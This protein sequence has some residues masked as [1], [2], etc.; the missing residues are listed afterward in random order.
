MMFCV[1][2]CVCGDAFEGG[3][4]CPYFFV[5]AALAVTRSA[6]VCLSVYSRFGVLAKQLNVAAL[7]N[8][9]HS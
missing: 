2:V 6:S 8:S 3:V 9:H 1:C 5:L 7:Q 4:I